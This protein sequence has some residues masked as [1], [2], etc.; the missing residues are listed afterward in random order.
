MIHHLN[1]TFNVYHSM[2]FRIF[3]ILGHC[4]HPE[5][6]PTSL[7][8]VTPHPHPHPTLQLLIY[9]LSVDLPFLGLSQKQ[10]VQF[11]TD[12]MF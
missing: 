1:C 6:R 8:T 12:F 3:T 5:G 10:I 4:H 2:A 11:C 7:S 9:F